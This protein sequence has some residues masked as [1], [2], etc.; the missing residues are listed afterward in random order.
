MSIGIK[1]ICY[2]HDY[3]RNICI[4]G[5]I[6][7]FILINFNAHNWQLI[8]KIVYTL[9]LTELKLKGSRLLQNNIKLEDQNWDFLNKI[10]K[11]AKF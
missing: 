5:D 10:T 7:I 1:H 9:A 11:T 3:D 6:F 8:L 2:P 4:I